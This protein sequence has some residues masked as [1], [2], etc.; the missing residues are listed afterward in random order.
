L[1]AR[2]KKEQNQKST[3]GLTLLARWHSVCRPLLSTAPENFRRQTFQRTAAVTSFA[4]P[5]ASSATAAL[6]A[7]PMV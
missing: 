1:A 4:N 5:P 7:S 2:D 3:V 6:Q